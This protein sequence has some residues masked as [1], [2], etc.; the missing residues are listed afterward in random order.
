MPTRILILLLVAIVLCLPGWSAP[1]AADK[2]Y[3]TARQLLETG[4]P[5]QAAA[6]FTKFRVD[7]PQDPRM[8]EAAF[9]LGCAYQQLGK[10]S[11]ALAAF[12]NVPAKGTTP[13]EKKLAANTRFQVA[14][15]HWEKG[16]YE[17]A[18]LA[19]RDCLAVAGEDT[20]LTA[21]AYYLLGRS[22]AQLG[23]DGEARQ[24]YD[25][26]VEIAPKHPLAPWS[27]YASGTLALRQSDFPRAAVTLEKVL[28]GYA[29]SEVVAPAALALG[30]TYAGQARASTDPAIREA[31]YAKAL[32]LLTAMQDD[33]KLPA[34]SRLRAKFSLA[35]IYANRQ[36]Y[37]R[38]E[39]AYA[40]A[41]ALLPPDHPW[42]A[43]A[44]LQRGHALYNAG[45]FQD[46]TAAYARAAEGK[47]DPDRHA[48]ALY[49]LGN[50][51]YQIAVAQKNTKADTEAILALRK[52]LGV[53]SA[54]HPLGAR[55]TLLLALCQEDLAVAGNADARVAAVG[56]FKDVLAK[57]P[58]SKE[59]SQASAGI[60]R[61]TSTM[62]RAELESVA[63]LLPDG[64]A[65]WSV[66]LRLA[67]EQFQ[68]GKYPEAI[69]AAKKVLAGKPDADL[70]ARAAFLIGAASQKLNRPKDAADAYR[71]VLANTKADDLILYAQRN[72]VQSCLDA[73][74][75]TEAVK[76]AQELVARPLTGKTPAERE[77]ELAERL[78][79][80]A[81]AS[82][83]VKQYPGALSGYARVVAECPSSPQVPFA[84]MGQAWVAET[85]RDSKLAVASYT[86][87]TATFPAHKLA[88]D[89]WFRLGLLLNEQKSYQPAI[90]ALKNVPLDYPA[91]DQ[92][93][94][95]TAWAYLDLGK[96]EEAAAQFTK[97]AEGF[98]KSPLAGE[99]L[100]QLGA[101]QMEK[102]QFPE[103]VKTLTRA[104]ALLGPDHKLQPAVA[105]KLA[106]CAMN[107]GDN[108]KAAELFGGLI[109]RYPASEQAAES[110][111]WQAQALENLGAARAAAARDL[112][113]QYLKKFKDGPLALDA[114][115]GMGRAAL[116]LNQPAAARA[117]FQAA[118]KLC[119]ELGAGKG[120]QLAE[121][122]ANVAPEAQYHLGQS[123]FLEKN[124]KQALAEFAAVA[125]YSLEPW[126][127]RSLL[128]M[129]RC[130]A[131]NGDKPAAE[132]TL[133]VLLK[134]FPK[135]DAAGQAPQVAKE[136]GVNLPQ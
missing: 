120:E 102:E 130:S 34:D 96:P 57:W 108:A 78:M 40:G 1:S 98:P 95:T 86:K 58:S 68:A 136:L 49:W 110:L 12:A 103:A 16:A 89:A 104:Q 56:A 6:L 84:L 71:T 87:M 124:Y 135:S 31:N 83:G 105:F 45:R 37:D 131:L 115:L 41:I 106:A 23:K 70:T 99:S 117:D 97:V 51:W 91:A 32:K 36:E 4:N 20:D 19:C 22:L 109:A 72:L 77:N 62:T 100:Y 118:L 134:N 73:G 39:A 2:A 24:A 122:A 10:F 88:A 65:S 114:A 61:M 76:P 92:A 11:E 50:S 55:A 63:G 47:G 17:P 7:F 33:V 25:K 81:E 82:I 94:Y 133:G 127:S 43:D 46:A 35:Q 52:F 8:T 74:Q 26:V 116:A 9:F 119:D 29:E 129:A 38:A 5:D 64:A 85:T 128:Q 113:G 18:A 48:Q 67:H 28:A 27:L 69:D 107:T 121:R 42:L 53:V 126:Y 60:T 66:A 3:A 79:L 93:A 44:H 125:I 13:E 75:F 14:E 80:L 90:D 54:K 111:F 112:Y 59:A 30:E 101:Y 123:Y 21:R 15:C 132:R